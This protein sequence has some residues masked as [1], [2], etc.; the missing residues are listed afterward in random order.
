MGGG[1]GR[2]VATA[3]GLKN[4]SEKLHSKEMDT[5]AVHGWS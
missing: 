4:C 2:E 1:V 3:S 5:G